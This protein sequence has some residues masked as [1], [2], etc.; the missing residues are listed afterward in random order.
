M[1]DFGPKTEIMPFRSYLIELKYETAQVTNFCGSKTAN[2]NIKTAVYT[3]VN[4]DS[5]IE[6]SKNHKKVILLSITSPKCQC[7]AE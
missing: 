4:G 6:N 7:A 2:I 1:T 3:H 5:H